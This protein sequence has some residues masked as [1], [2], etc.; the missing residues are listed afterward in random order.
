MC[1]QPR[2]TRRK[3]QRRKVA[4]PASLVNWIGRGFRSASFS[5]PNETLFEHFGEMSRAE[6]TACQGVLELNAAATQELG[7]KVV[8]SRLSN[9]RVFRV[10][11]GRP[12]ETLFESAYRARC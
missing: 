11:F 10:P 9:W 3:R 5:S 8:A 7:R 2:E 4:L 6:L 1:D 12:S